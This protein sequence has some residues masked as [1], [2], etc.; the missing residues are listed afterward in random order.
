MI[1]IK[2]YGSGSKGNLYYLTSNDTKIVLE[3]GVETSKIENMLVE[4][5]ILATDINACITSHCHTDH[6]CC[7]NF[8]QDYN[9][10]TFCTRDTITRYRMMLNS[11]N[12]PHIL[13]H[14]KMFKI[15][16]LLFLPF[17]VNHRS[18]ECFGFVIKD[19]IDN[20]CVLFITDFCEC[21]CDFKKFKFN[22]IFIECNY[23]DSNLENAIKNDDKSEA[24]MQIKHKRQLNTH[25]SLN[26][27]L[28]ILNSIDLSNCDKLTLIHVSDELG[29]RKMMTE[30]II[31][32]FGVNCIALCSSGEEFKC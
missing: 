14:Y 6:S 3:C 4:N 8:F 29:D 19:T 5:K 12:P 13:E 27:L 20:Y 32:E 17:N 30:K 22:Q 21:K 26:N 15:K 23:V 28:V 18:A 10:N 16:N 9:V 11:F 31:E 24:F 25:M 7:I 1:N 2:S